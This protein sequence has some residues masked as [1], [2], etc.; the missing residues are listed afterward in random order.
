MCS[1]FLK[2]TIFGSNGATNP[3]TLDVR[4]P[5]HTPRGLHEPPLQPLRQ[6]SRC[7]QRAVLRAACFALFTQVAFETVTNSIPTTPGPALQPPPNPI[8]SGAKRCAMAHTA[9]VEVQRTTHC[10]TC[11]DRCTRVSRGC[12]Q[13]SGPMAIRL[14]FRNPW[15]NRALNGNRDPVATPSSLATIERPTLADVLVTMHLAMTVSLASCI[16]L[17]PN[18]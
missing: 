9:A 13:T 1:W 2:G 16:R 11:D 17:T 12:R 4:L 18:S 15:Q 5:A 3:V 14:C 6:V 10:E 8:K 7:P